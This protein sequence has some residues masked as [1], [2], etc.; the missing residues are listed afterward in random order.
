MEEKA[1]RFSEPEETDDSKETLYYRKSPDILGT[2]RDCG[3]MH[4][5]FT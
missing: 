4:R 5:N 1:E 2:H 3:L